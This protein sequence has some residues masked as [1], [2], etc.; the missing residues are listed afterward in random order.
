MDWYRNLKKRKVKV[1]VVLWFSILVCNLKVRFQHDYLIML[2]KSFSISH[3]KSYHILINKELVEQ[4]AT[5]E[6]KKKHPFL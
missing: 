2:C 3:F 5:D 4:V 6:N 1:E